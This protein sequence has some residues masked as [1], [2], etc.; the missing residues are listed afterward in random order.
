MTATET[1]PEAGALG[2]AGAGCRGLAL[3]AALLAAGAV[4]LSLPALAGVTWFDET[5][6]LALARQPLGDLIS[7]AAADVHPPL[8]YLL[9][10]GVYLLAG[11][12]VAAYRLFSVAGAVATAALGL[13]H[14]RRD[15]GARAGLLFTFAACFTPYLAYTAM[16]IRMY[17]WAG[18]AVTLCFLYACRIMRAVRVGRRPRAGAWVAFAVSSLAAAYLHYFGMLAAFTLN[19]AVLASILAAGRRAKRGAPA[20]AGTSAPAGE[21]A[22]GLVAPMAPRREL[23]VFAAQ[24]AAQVAAYLPW[25]AV[26]AAQL[27]G[28]TGGRFWVTFSFPESLLQ[29]LAYPLA[30]EQVAYAIADAGAAGAAPAALVTLALLFAAAVLLHG[31]VR[32]ERPDVR[33]AARLACAVYIGVG[34]L[35]LAVSQLMGSLIVYYRYFS[36]ALGPVLVAV[37]ATLGEAAER[38]AQVRE[39]A[40]RA[41]PAA[42][43][44]A[45]A[46]RTAEVVLVGAVAGC[47]VAHQALALS[48]ALDARNN[49]V[50]SYLEDLGT[51][52]AAS[53]SAAGGAAEGAAVRLPV[54]SNDITV[55][56]CAWASDAQLDLAYANF[57]DGY[58]NHAYDCYAPE[59]VSTDTASQALAGAGSR[60]AYLNIAQ[61][62]DPSVGTVKDPAADAARIEELTGARTVETRAFERPYEHRTYY[63]TIF[64]LDG[65]DAAPTAGLQPE[66]EGVAP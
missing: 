63:V 27:A 64:E 48:Q 57:F 12:S 33:R 49:A 60:F 65:G 42:R 58:W 29:I 37:A 56:G 19:V 7:I 52:E 32:S 36:I 35:G 1:H 62:E 15:F 50:F 13:T 59:L 46:L 22:A 4:F 41:A 53:G 51:S 21:P 38:R 16:Q 25:L 17:S 24:A 8:Y 2:A 5:Y 54:L 66:G 43:L 44:Q 47:G 20:P 30:S 55:L 31:M 9:L 3:H 45:L 39:G 14:V 23:V 40:S 34:A 11:E 18:F 61:S 6:S 10:H 28:K 26:L